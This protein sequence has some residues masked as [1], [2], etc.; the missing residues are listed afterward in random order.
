MILPEC[1]WSGE[2]V[3]ELVSVVGRYEDVG[4]TPALG[5]VLQEQDAHGVS[6]NVRVLKLLHH[7]NRITKFD[8][9]AAGAS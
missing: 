7:Q 6:V 9:N 1:S 2:P 4:E 3:I 8:K 5:L